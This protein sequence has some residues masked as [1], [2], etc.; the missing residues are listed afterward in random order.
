M[1]ASPSIPE[2]GD[3]RARFVEQRFASLA[4]TITDGGSRSS[5]TRRNAARAAGAVVHVANRQTSRDSTPPRRLPD[6]WRDEDGA[7]RVPRPQATCGRRRRHDSPLSETSPRTTSSASPSRASKQLVGPGDDDGADAIELHG[8][9]P[10]QRRRGFRESPRSPGPPAT[11][12]N[13]APRAGAVMGTIGAA[14]PSL[15]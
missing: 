11:P 6:G 14:E 1:L 7:R 2:R 13:R 5:S 8:R 12:S 15:S 10:Q 4:S 9:S 3:R